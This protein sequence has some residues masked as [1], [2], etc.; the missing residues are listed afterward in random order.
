MVNMRVCYN[1]EVALLELWDKFK[2][3]SF[4]LNLDEVD[5]LIGILQSVSSTMCDAGECEL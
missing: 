2:H 5:E 4:E 3:N 1:G